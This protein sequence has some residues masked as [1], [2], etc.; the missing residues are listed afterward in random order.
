MLKIG[1]T[2]GIGSGKSTI[3][4][5]F[6]SFGIPIL[7][8]DKAAKYVMQYDKQVLQQLMTQFGEDI[9]LD[10]VLQFNLLGKKV[11]G[12][13]QTL[14]QLNAIVHPAVASYTALWQSQQ[15]ASYTIKEAA[16][17]IESGAYKEVDYIIGVVASETTRIERVKKRTPHLSEED[18]KNRM[19][20]Q[21]PEEEKMAFY[22]F[23]VNN[24]NSDLL[25]PQVLAIHKKILDLSSGAIK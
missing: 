6:R 13:T 7:D 17:L 23:T 3:C 24:N 4:Q 14:Q 21:M 5:I 15:H 1:I 8:A 11:F 19:K 12:N 9:F 20:Q 18:I 10:H 22:N 16:I 25:L 2:G